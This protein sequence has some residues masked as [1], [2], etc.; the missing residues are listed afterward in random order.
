MLVAYKVSKF[1]DLWEVNASFA[2]MQAKF[3]YSFRVW[4]SL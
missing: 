3:L 1:I 4:R 2:T